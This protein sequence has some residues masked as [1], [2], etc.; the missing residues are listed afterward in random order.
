MHPRPST[1]IGTSVSA[2]LG[3][4]DAAPRAP[5]HRPGYPTRRTLGHRHSSHRIESR[6]TPDEVHPHWP[7]HRPMPQTISRPSGFE[8]PQL[9]EPPPVSPQSVHLDGAQAP[10]PPPPLPPPSAPRAPSRAP[11]RGHLSSRGQLPRLRRLKHRGPI[12]ARRD[13]LLDLRV[14]SL[15]ARTART[16]RAAGNW[17]WCRR[18]PPRTRTQH[19]AYVGGHLGDGAEGAVGEGRV[20]IGQPGGRGWRRA[21]AHSRIVRRRRR[22]RRRRRLPRPRHSRPRNGRQ[23]R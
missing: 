11:S 15:P 4:C 23:A 6:R 16:A 8:R 22:R 18:S 19:G 12:R 10:T 21:L 9:D 5:Q 3:A 7:S 2:K 20:G 13:Q 14:T 1:E 17:R